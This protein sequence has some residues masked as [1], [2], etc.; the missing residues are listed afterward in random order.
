MTHHTYT[1]TEQDYLLFE[2]KITEDVSLQF[3]D[4]SIEE[5]ENSPV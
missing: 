5:S 2:S 4:Q 1:T 3:P